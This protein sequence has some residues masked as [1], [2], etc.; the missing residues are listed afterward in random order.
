[1][2]SICVFCGSS[3]GDLA[4][5]SDACRQLADSFRRH[6]IGLVFGGGN[7]GLM[8]KLADAQLSHGGEV[9]GVIP[10]KLA[11][12]NLAHPNVSNMHV[13]K[14]MHERKALMAE[15][16]DGFIALPGGIGTFEE[17]FEALTWLQLDYHQKP[18]GLLNICGFY[19]LLIQFLEHASK[20]Q[21][22]K[23]AHKNT[24]LVDQH[25]DLLIQQMFSYEG[26][27]EGKWF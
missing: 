19:D 17:L 13:V 1:M 3:Q 12:L 25:P 22:L 15:L 2:K 21:F 7:V 26:T 6:D 27:K 23:T 10:Q 24:L 11:D 8:G 18:V 4:D 20:S 14:D 5:Y 9:I 16:S